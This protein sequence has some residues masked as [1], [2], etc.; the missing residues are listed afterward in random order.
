MKYLVSVIFLIFFSV[1]YSASLDSPDFSNVK[2]NELSWN[3]WINKMK[4]QL[5]KENFKKSTIDILDDLTF[6]PRVIELDR[7][8]PEFKLTFDEYLSKVIGE[9]KKK[10]INIEFNKNKELLKK[11]ENKFNVNSKILVAL[12]GIETSFGRYTG[13][14]DI[15]RSLASLS[16]DGRRTNFFQK[17][18]K[19]SLRI[20]DNGH[21][22][23]KDFF[24]SWAGAFGQT[25]FMPSTFIKYAVDFDG[26]NRK[27]LFKKPDSLASG[28]NYLNKSG[29]KSGITW[30]EKFD[31]K[32]T[33]KMKSLS[34]K[35]QFKKINFWNNLGFPIKKNYEDNQLLR[36]VIPDSNFNECYLVSQNFD[37]ILNWNR[38]NYFALTV[39]LFADEIN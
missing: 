15:L 21:F 9:K 3:D 26:D 32:I 7:K 23:K 33:K 22:L 1:S 24:G 14:F 28:A 8:Q 31:V 18:L 36:L 29:W 12:W 13:K 16:Y 34:D 4:S 25:Q 19:N 27:N 37:V 5:E 11:I 6:N 17:E 10:K 38:S 30:G 2:K 39:F 20:I 35:K